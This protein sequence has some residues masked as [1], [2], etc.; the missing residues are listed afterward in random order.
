MSGFGK[1]ETYFVSRE[2][3]SI[4]W[5]VEEIT[6]RIFPGIAGW[7]AQYESPGGDHSLA[8]QNFLLGV[9]PFEAKVI[10][11]DG[12]NFIKDFPNH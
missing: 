5:A 8:A 4:P 6:R 9:L 10:V 12:V 7:Q 11:Q 1:E 3:I 2:H